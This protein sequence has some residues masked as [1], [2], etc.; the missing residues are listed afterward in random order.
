MA[1]ITWNGSVSSVWSVAG[2]WTGGVPGAADDVYFT[3][4]AVAVASYD[5]SA[6][7]LN[8]LNVDAS[9][10]GTFGELGTYVKYKAT[11]TNIGL[12]T[13]DGVGGGSRRLNLNNALT[14]TAV[15]NVYGS[16]NSPLDAGYTPVRLLLTTGSLLNVFGGT[17]GVA[18]DPSETSTVATL[19]T[20]NNPTVTLGA[21]VTI[22]TINAYSGLV[23][24][25]TVNAVTTASILGNSSYRW[26]GTGATTTLN[27]GKKVTYI[28]SGTITNLNIYGTGTF[29]ASG[30]NTAFTVTNAICYSGGSVNDNNLRVTWTNGVITSGCNLN[31]VTFNL[32]NSKKVNVS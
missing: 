15:V 24:N 10:T 1:K 8:S 18:L 29:D 16:G 13:T 20:S 5:S 22:T 3:E 2:N 21:G 27:A 19:T 26:G 17:V 14:S 11:V 28:G 25:N 32:G 23:I 12:P 9:Y 7:T 6:V 30:G 4:N 31:D